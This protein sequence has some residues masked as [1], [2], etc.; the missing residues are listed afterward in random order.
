MLRNAVLGFA[1]LVLICGLALLIVQPGAALPPLVFGAILT[2]GTVFER[3]RYKSAM[4]PQSARGAPTGE[5]FVDPV[6]GELMEVYYDA[7]TGERS[8]VRI[9]QGKG[10]G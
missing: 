4:T 7:S 2:L 8:Y 10:T 5:R 6:S 1:L 9:S 3:W